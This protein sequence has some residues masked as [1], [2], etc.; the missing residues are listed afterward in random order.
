MKD[1]FKRLANMQMERSWQ[2]LLYLDVILPGI[3]F[4]LALL[5]PMESLAASL[6]RLFHSYSVYVSNPI[7]NLAN[8]MGIVGLA[9]HL[10]ALIMALRRKD[11]LDLLLSALLT[12]AVSLYFYLGLN[13]QLVRYLSF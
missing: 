2:W 5:L 4:L 1:T 9:V 3:L 8:F 11:K 13:Y 7:P 10:G 12:L 6:A